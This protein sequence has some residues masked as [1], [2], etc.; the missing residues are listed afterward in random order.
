MVLFFGIAGILVTATIVGWIL[1][2]QYAA[3]EPNPVIENLNSRIYA[4]WAMVALIGFAF[5]FGKAGVIVLFALFSFAA[6]REFITL[7]YTRRGDHWA[8]IAAF[9][10][11]TAVVSL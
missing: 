10:A 11:S 1:T 6:L 4:W 8:L 5:I 9:F 3:E 7:S 2:L